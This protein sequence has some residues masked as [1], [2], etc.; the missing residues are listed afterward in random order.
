MIPF[1]PLPGALMAAALLATPAGAIDLTDMTESER[2]AF[3]AEVREYL[4]D[5]PEVIMEAVAVLEQRET[6]SQEAADREMIGALEDEIFDDGY[7]WVGGNP[8]GDV[9]LVE[10]I[11][12]RCGY[13]RRAHDDVNELVESDGDIRLVIKEL[14]ILGPDSMASSRFAI[15]TKQIAGDEAYH[16]AMEALIQMTGE[17]N[18][19]TLERLAESLGLD[20]DRILVQMESPEVTEVISE[21]RAL[22]QRLGINGTP[23]FVLPD[24][25]VRGY[26][27]LDG[28]REIVADVREAG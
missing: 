12:Y 26:M 20:A 21:T 13:C 15:A 8:E 6:A 9:T 16:A 27:P 28:M 4:L 7:S 11:D 22:A 1:R 19:I 14:P 2:A 10:F 24:R 17:V 3:R 25:M 23:T 18:E 5:N